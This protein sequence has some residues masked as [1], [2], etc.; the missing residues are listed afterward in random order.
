MDIRNPGI[1]PLLAYVLVLNSYIK[2]KDF[3]PATNIAT[4]KGM[5]VIFIE[6]LP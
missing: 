5:E 3:S 1:N 4:S 6:A 2:S